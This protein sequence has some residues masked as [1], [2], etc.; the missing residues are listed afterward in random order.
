MNM[1]IDYSIQVVTTES[2]QISIGEASSFIGYTTPPPLLHIKDSREWLVGQWFQRTTKKYLW[3]V[4][5]VLPPSLHNKDSSNQ[6]VGQWFQ[7]TTKK[8]LLGVLVKV[9]LLELFVSILQIMNSFIYGDTIHFNAYSTLL[10]H[11]V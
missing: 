9:A 2:I 5:A 3:G 7:R 10:I 11:T 4:Q 1:F 6:L 8:Y